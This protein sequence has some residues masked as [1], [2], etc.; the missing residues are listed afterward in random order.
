[1]EW[2]LILLALLTFIASAIGT[3]TGFGTSSFM[4]PVLVLFFP[5]LETLLF[6]G[7][8]HFFGDVWKM[9]LFKSGIKWRLILL[10]GIPGIVFSWIGSSLVL[11]VNS[12]VLTGIIGL[13][14]IAYTLFLF[15][16]PTFKIPERTETAIVGGSFY[17]LIAGISGIGGAVRGAFLS[18]FN[19]KKSV[20]LFT[21]GA[22]AFF[23]DV[24]RIGNYLIGGVSL[25]GLLFWGL[26]VFV[27]ISYLGAKV[28]ERFV[29]RIPEKKFRLVVAAFLLIIGFKLFLFP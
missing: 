28:A 21:T 7:T 14:L 9:L 12:E 26:L 3:L 22:I 25:E 20:Y 15:A 18:A 1:M 24:T 10:F 27:P 29:D 17:G 23:V 11:N 5:P 19:L 13:I 2:Q 6:V 8:I 16:T 4:V